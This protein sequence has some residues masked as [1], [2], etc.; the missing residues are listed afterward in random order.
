MPCWKSSK[1]LTF[2]N[3]GDIAGASL[4]HTTMEGL[5]TIVQQMRR[6]HKSHTNTPDL[7]PLEGQKAI[8]QAISLPADMLDHLPSKLQ[9]VHPPMAVL[10]NCDSL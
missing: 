8:N 1:V 4:L 9:Q 7:S 2:Q 5:L 3:K 10:S 6:D